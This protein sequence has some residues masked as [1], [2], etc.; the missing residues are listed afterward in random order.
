MDFNRIDAHKYY[1][2][3]DESWI[4]VRAFYSY[5]K[6]K[7]LISIYLIFVN[8]AK[9]LWLKDAKDVREYTIELKIKFDYITFWLQLF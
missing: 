2:N 1:G 3:M 7:S 6:L 9:L 4:F 8:L 5:F